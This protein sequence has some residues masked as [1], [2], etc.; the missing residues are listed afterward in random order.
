MSKVHM[1]HIGIFKYT[2]CCGLTRDELKKTD[3]ITTYPNLVTCSVI[4]DA[5]KKRKG[6]RKYTK[7]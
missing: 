2:Y 6:F 4:Y 1:F 5:N 3:K 7:R